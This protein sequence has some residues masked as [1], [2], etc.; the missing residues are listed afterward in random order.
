MC[1]FRMRNISL[2]MESNERWI[3][4]ERK[5]RAVRSCFRSRKEDCETYANDARESGSAFPFLQN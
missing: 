4:K 5:P 2:D 3:L 1:R